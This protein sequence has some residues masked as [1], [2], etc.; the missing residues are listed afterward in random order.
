[1][2]RPGAVLVCLIGLGLSAAACGNRN[3]YHYH[4]TVVGLD[5][6]GNVSGDS[7]S[8]HLVLGYSRRLVVFLPPEVEK[9]LESGQPADPTEGV[10]LPATVFC[11]QVKASLGG[12]SAFR[13]ILA[14]GP[15]AVQ[16][17]EQLAAEAAGVTDWKDHNFVC[18]G[19]EM[20]RPDGGAPE[21]ARPTAAPLVR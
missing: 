7:P 8:G 14:T 20:P 21:S 12:V 5:I 6:A 3:L 4:R 19:F 11:T 1:M 15:P 17:A 16:Y 9:A 10:P 18:P 13:E 2:L